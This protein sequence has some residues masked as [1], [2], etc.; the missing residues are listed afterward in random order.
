MAGVKFFTGSIVVAVALCFG[1]VPAS[2]AEAPVPG[3]IPV[4]LLVDL[5]TGQTLYA[6]QAERRFVPASVTKVMT[7]YTAF[8]LVDEGKLGLNRQFLYTQELE[9]QWY[10]EGSNMFLRAG[11]RPTIGQL[12]LGITT[13]SGNDASVAMA[14]AATGSLDAWLALMNAN[15]RELGMRDT[16]FGSPNGYPDGG[17]TYTS[18][19]DLVLLGRAITQDYPGLYRRYFGHRGMTWRDIAQNN[20]DPVTGR[21]PG[22]DGLKT[23][24]TNEAGYTF[25]GSAQRDGR[26]LMMVLA[27]APNAR[28]R[29]NAARELLEWGFA[30]FEPQ[31]VFEQGRVIGTAQVQDGAERDV[32]LQLPEAFKA[33]LPEGAQ[34]AQDA[35]SLRI[36]Y[37]GPIAAP[38]YAGDAIARLQLLEGER[39][40]LETPLVAAQS[41]EKANP[42]ERIANAFTR[43]FG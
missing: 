3:D 20:H 23:G 27:A 12:L 10:A 5:S 32:A 4:A 11:E 25:L 37:R 22:A 8:K 29:D 24:F 40:V 18:A 42:I 26:R 30:E 15:A 35:L 16:H 33:A 19:R 43:W 7:V 9:Q 14:V 28:M 13:V 2:P 36:A 17:Q 38:I 34:S 1:A 31:I 6:R 21:V 41:V 39:V